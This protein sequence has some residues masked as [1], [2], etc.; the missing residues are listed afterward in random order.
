MATPKEA[1]IKITESE[2]VSLKI[3]HSLLMRRYGFV[4]LILT[5]IDV[6]LIQLRQLFTALKKVVCGESFSN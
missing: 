6:L 5:L 1:D 2:R 3:M 4:I